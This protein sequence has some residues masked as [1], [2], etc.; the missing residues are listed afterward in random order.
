MPDQQYLYDP[1]LSLESDARI[2]AE[3]LIAAAR[4][5]F[6]W[7]TLP[8]GVRHFRGALHRL[9]REAVDGIPQGGLLV[10]PLRWP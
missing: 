3:I 1:E 10:D 4:S 5:G 6:Y 9:Y 2:A 7:P 8:S